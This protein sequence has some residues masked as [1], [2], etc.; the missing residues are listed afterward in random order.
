MSSDNKDYKKLFD[1]EQYQEAQEILVKLLAEK[2]DDEIITLLARCYWHLGQPD[3]AIKL[4]TIQ[5]HLSYDNRVT[6]MLCHYGLEE[7][8]E[9][10]Q[11]LREMIQ[12]RETARNYYMLS[13]AEAK[14]RLLYYLDSATKERIRGLLKKAAS[15][16]DGFPDLYVKLT[17]LTDSKDWKGREAILFEALQKFPDDNEI[18]LNMTALHLEQKNYEKSLD[19]LKSLIK[20]NTNS[21]ALWYALTAYVGLNDYSQ[22]RKIVHRLSFKDLEDKTRLMSEL[23]FLD[24]QYDQWLACSYFQMGYD[25]Q[26]SA[27]KDHLRNTYINLKHNDIVN[28]ITDFKKGTEVAIGCEFYGLD[29]DILVSLDHGIEVFKGFDIVRDICETLLLLRYENRL[30]DEQV[31]AYIAFVIYQS[32]YAEDILNDFKSLFPNPERELMDY[33][34]E[35]LGNRP[36]LGEIFFYHYLHDNNVKAIA[37]YIDRCTWALENDRDFDPEIS[38]YYFE[39]W[40]TFI[41]ESGEELALAVYSRFENATDDALDAIFS[42]VY[43]DFWRKVLFKEKLFEKVRQI[44]KRFLSIS[45][46]TYWLFEYAYSSASLGY[47][48]EALNTYKR[49]IDIQPRN[50]S[51][52]NNL[53]VIY[54]NMGNPEQ[55]LFHFQTAIEIDNT[56]EIA[57][58]NYARVFNVVEEMKAARHKFEKT[59]ASIRQKGHEAGLSSE[60]QEQLTQEYWHSDKTTGA[61]EAEYG[62]KRVS[63][64][65]YPLETDTECPNCHLKLFYT[66]RTARSENKKLCLG[67]GHNSK[68]RCNCAFCTRQAE[69]RRR[70]QEEARKREE[71]RQWQK[72]KDRYFNEGYVLWAVDQLARKHKEFMSAFITVVTEEENPTWEAICNHA[73]VVSKETYVKKLKDLKLL[74]DKPGGGV[75]RNEAVTLE[76]LE[77]ESVRNISK[78]LRFDVFQ[79]DNHTC[80]YCGRTTPDVVLEVDHLIPVSKGGTDDFANLVTSCFDCNR[81]KSDKIIQE[82]TGGFSQEA[83]RE[84]IRR[85]RSEVLQERRARIDEVKEA[86]LEAL[87]RK[88][89]NK[90]DETAI[91]HFVERYESDWIIAAIQITGWKQIK[92]HIKYTAGILRNWAKDGPPDNIANPNAMLSD[93]PA[94]EKQI[95]YIK[96]LLDNL[97][98]QLADFYHVTEFE[99]LTMLDATNLIKELTSTDEVN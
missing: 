94:T 65:T 62:V 97:D 4:L 87:G 71:E 70:Q 90:Q 19:I 18:L 31:L 75:V 51:A 85:K 80:Q 3:A 48:D 23:W 95:V 91:Y 6:L 56:D 30:I 58:R 42:V 88:Y 69:E 15:L 35:Y 33:V 49:L 8:D 81:G 24:E 39:D 52:H 50:N 44:S 98:L 77:V 36:E 64:L 74:L 82:F 9:M 34:V 79:R 72:I 76:M 86:W 20:E 89:L 83:W 47:R 13:I 54:E 25:P 28:A 40:D 26:V 7:W 68:R 60:Q 38:N 45:E 5:E 53:G 99:K 84:K 16:D 93:K 29:F 11:Q 67:C 27:I 32:D 55:A 57:S 22:A 43:S 63:K 92:D 46:G 37:C 10:A 14:G 41:E 73:G 1:A 66:N 96:A 2:P 12:V 59:V 17:Q 21:Q 78:S 61:I